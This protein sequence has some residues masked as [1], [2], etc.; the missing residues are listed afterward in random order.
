MAAGG[1]E[2][3]DIHTITNVST[4]THAP[5]THKIATHEI[6]THNFPKLSYDS[7]IVHCLSSK[8]FPTPTDG[9]LTTHGTLAS[10]HVQSL[11]VQSKQ[12]K[13]RQ[14]RSRSDEC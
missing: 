11:H 6:D 3:A 4:T 7:G 10:L 1:T 13:S 9:A 2:A 5:H 8:G 14:E 12:D